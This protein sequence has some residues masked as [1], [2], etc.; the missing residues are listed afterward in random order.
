MS[1][2][3]EFC[4]EQPVR[5]YAPGDLIIG[6]NH[7]DGRLRV[8][9]KGVVDITKRGTTINRLSSPGS[10]LGEIAILLDQSFGASVTAVEPT[11]VYVIENGERFLHDHPELMSLVAKLLAMR[12][13]NLTD[14]LVEIQEQLEAESD[15]EGFGAAGQLNGVL[16]RLVEHHLDREY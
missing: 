14:E 13:K 12:L 8:L 2:L 4:A 5:S 9:K 3:L 1:T 15:D 7:K 10:V 16:R 6:E 11:E